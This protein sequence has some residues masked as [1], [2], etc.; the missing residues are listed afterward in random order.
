[1]LTSTLIS[2]GVDFAKAVY[3]YLKF[4]WK[5][6]RDKKKNIMKNSFTRNYFEAIDEFYEEQD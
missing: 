1:M 6:F 5:Q 3:P 4:K 2:I